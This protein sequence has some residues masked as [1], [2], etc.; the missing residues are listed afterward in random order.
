MRV[1]P[2]GAAVNAR[3]QEVEAEHLEHAL[4]ALSD[5]E[6]ATCATTLVQL[7]AYLHELEAGAPPRPRSERSV[8]VSPLR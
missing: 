4:T 6:L 8:E 3:V 2:A 5:E 7:V 1:T